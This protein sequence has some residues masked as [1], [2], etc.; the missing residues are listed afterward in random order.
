[1]NQINCH[2]ACFT[3]FAIL[4]P[5]LASPD[6]VLGQENILLAGTSQVD[7]TPTRLPVIVNGGFLPR[8][9]DSVLDPLYARCLMLESGKERLVFVVI[10]N[11]MLPVELA[12]RIKS[13]IRNRTGIPVDRIMFSATHCHSAPSLCSALGV[14][15]D[16]N[17]VAFLPDKVVQ[18]VVEAKENLVPARIGWAVGDDRNN[19]YCRRFL[20]KKG[21]AST[22]PFS[23]K[24][25]D[26]AMMNPGH[27]NP[28]K[29][30]RT[31]PVDTAVA[32]L[33][34]R[35]QD[36]KPLAVL[37]NYSTHYAGA[38]PG[39]SGDYFGVFSRQIKALI[40]EQVGKEKMSER[41]LGIMT[42]GTSG[43]ANCVD[44]LNPKRKFDYK[45][46]GH[47]TAEAAAQ[48]WSNIEYVD[49]PL[50]QAVE[51]RITIPNRVPTGEEVQAAREHLASLP[52]GKIV[53]TA[54][55][56][57][58]STVMMADWP[59]TTEIPIQAI[60]IG[61]LGIVALPV[62]TY[63][64]TGL[65]IKARSPF[66]TTFVISM[67]NGYFGYVPPEEQHALGGYNTWRTQTSCLAEDAETT[68]RETAIQLLESLDR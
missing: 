45:T 44:F 31:G 8:V 58:Q 3:L 56:Y 39:L 67:A 7:I 11:C 40:T 47:E 1:M 26:R 32:V 27:A 29:I 5:F 55:V 53:K 50:L 33:S 57:A 20:M 19:V 46:V 54:D 13:E 25:D 52:N 24:K 28:N 48:V 12:D 10:D 64:I 15:A 42:N 4:F 21:T 61:E 6:R 43:D 37:S 22:N 16:E 68:I 30:A 9:V 18:V 17:Y 51:K 63:G 14:S 41:F 35:T 66:A 34:V 65:E 2:I 36:E 62:E 60:R 59:K 23:G 38:G 49:R